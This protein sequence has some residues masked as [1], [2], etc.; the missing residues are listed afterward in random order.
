MDPLLK[1]PGG[2]R[3]LLPKLINFVPKSYRRYVEPFFGS[4]AF[5]FGIKPSRALISDT[6][7]ELMGCYQTIR[8]YPKEVAN[9]LLKMKNTAEEYYKTRSSRPKGAIHKAA[10]LIYV[11]RLSFNGIY[12]VNKKGAFNVPYGYRTWLPSPAAN[13][14][15]SIS[16]A[17][18]NCEMQTCD[19]AESLSTCRKNDFVYLDPP[20]TVAHGQNGFL[21]YNANL[22]AWEDQ[23]RLAEAARILQK[24]GCKVLMS[25]AS[26]ESIRSLYS[27]F[28]IIEVTRSSTIAAS[29]AY[30]GYVQE[31]IITNIRPRQTSEAEP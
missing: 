12:R 3:H 18:Q 15:R 8:E 11:T 14:I 27:T 4:G 25:N 31:L 28:E 6:N 22:F 23:V 5:F 17:L 29:S 24:K 7:E 16:N 2:K 13:Q 20:Y 21:K 10:R 19:F 1:W 26:H 30:R 9:R